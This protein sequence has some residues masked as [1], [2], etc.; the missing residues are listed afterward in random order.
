[1]KGN[2]EKLVFSDCSQYAEV[3]KHDKPD[4]NTPFHFPLRYPFAI[5]GFYAHEPN[6]YY[7]KDY[8]HLNFLCIIL[9]KSYSGYKKQ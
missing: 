2:V 8:A 5:Q 6:A 9:A 4:T 1:M 7:Q 3:W